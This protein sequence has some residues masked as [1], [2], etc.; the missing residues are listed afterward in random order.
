MSALLLGQ[1]V[2]PC[3]LVRLR[4]SEKLGEL[5]EPLG[6][7]NSEPSQRKLEGATIIQ[8]WSRHK[9][10]SKRRASYKDDDMI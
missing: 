10:M 7:D 8:K 1:P 6:R 5:R 2:N 9:V 4:T 3:G